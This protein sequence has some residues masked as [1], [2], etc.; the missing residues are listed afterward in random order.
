MLSKIDAES[1]YFYLSVINNNNSLFKSL[2]LRYS[3]FGLTWSVCCC[4][5]LFIFFLLCS[6]SIWT[7]RNKLSL[8]SFRKGQLHITFAKVYCFLLFFGF[9]PLFVI[10]SHLTLLFSRSFFLLFS[11]SVLLVEW[12]TT[13]YGWMHNENKFVIFI[14]IVIA[15]VL[16]FSYLI[17]IFVRAF[18]ISVSIQGLDRLNFLFVGFWT[19]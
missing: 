3:H 1:I 7:D 10:S 4:Y 6:C 19:L 5:F 13:A 18:V 16:S 12:W 17:L 2:L 15:V 9:S 14:V 8:Y 11:F